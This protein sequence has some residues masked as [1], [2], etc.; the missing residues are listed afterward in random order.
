MGGGGSPTS[1]G[2]PIISA[3]VAI[4]SVIIFVIKNT[5][6]F[7]STSRFHRRQ[8]RPTFPRSQ[9]RGDWRLPTPCPR[10]IAVVIDARSMYRR[11]LVLSAPLDTPRILAE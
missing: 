11:R 4:N 6:L 7:S 1:A 2:H 8:I 5:P 10:E 9:V 3:H